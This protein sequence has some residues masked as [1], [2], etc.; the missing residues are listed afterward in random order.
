MNMNWRD[1]SE[2]VRWL[3]MALAGT[4]V[5]NVLVAGFI[6][7]TN[8]GTPSSALTVTLPGQIGQFFQA[9]SNDSWMTMAIAQKHH[10]DDPSGD[11]YSIFF[12]DGVKFQYPPSSLFFWKLLPGLLVGPQS[13]LTETPLRQWLR[14]AS[15]LAVLSTVALSIAIFINSTR[16]LRHDRRVS[17]RG[18]VGIVVMAFGLGIC[19]YPLSRGYRLGQIQVFIGFLTALALLCYTQG[20]RAA[21]GICVGVCCL[22]KPHYSLILLWGVIRRDWRF[23]S[24]LAVVAGLGLALAVKGFGL[25]NHLRYV[26]ALREMSLHGEAY[27]RNQSVNGIAHRLLGNGEAVRFRLESFAP[28]HPTVYYLTIVSSIAILAVSLWPLKLRTHCSSMDLAVALMGATMASPIAWEHHYGVF[29]PVF[30]LAVPALM[31]TRPAGRWTGLLLLLSFLMVANVVARPD[32][33]FR[34]PLRSLLGAHVFV[35]ALILWSLCIAGRTAISREPGSA[36]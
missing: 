19:F 12:N 6:V 17:T 23:S 14:M 27:W 8:N 33:I 36:Q 22:I 28:Y 15:L 16:Q 7:A 2:P 18:I 34:S 5:A 24:S 4:I 30:G 11:L 32:L 9:Q 29:L 10:E 21:A 3:C 20:M 35:G 31:Q 25:D 1:R 26:D 13:L